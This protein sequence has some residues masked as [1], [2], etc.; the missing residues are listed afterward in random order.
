VAAVAAWK[1]RPRVVNGQ[2]VAQ[3]TSVTLRFDVED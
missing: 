2:A 3:R 1:F